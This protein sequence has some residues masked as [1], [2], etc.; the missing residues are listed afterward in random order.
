MKGTTFK[1]SGI[2][3]KQLVLKEEKLG[4]KDTMRYDR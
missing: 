4:L 1:G 2:N 3:L